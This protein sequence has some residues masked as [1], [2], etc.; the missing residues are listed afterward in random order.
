MINAMLPTADGMNT[1]CCVCPRKNKSR[2]KAPST[3]RNLNSKGT[4]TAAYTVRNKYS[5][6][7]VVDYSSMRTVPAWKSYNMYDTLL[8]ARDLNH[9]LHTAV[10]NRKSMKNKKYFVYMICTKER[11]I[12]P[13]KQYEV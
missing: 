12:F 13:V 2:E 4:Y 1:C 11:V 3:D 6:S 9:M 5:Y 8:H 10:V 7:A